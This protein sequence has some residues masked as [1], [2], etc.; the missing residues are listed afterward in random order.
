[1]Y[2]DHEPV[3]LAVRFVTK[4]RKRHPGS[5]TAPASPTLAEASTVCHPNFRATCVR[6]A[7]TVPN[8]ALQAAGSVR[9][10]C[11]TRVHVA[12]TTLYRLRAVLLCE[13]PGDGAR[14]ARAGPLG[15]RGA[16]RLAVRVRDARG[17]P[18]V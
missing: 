6:Q 7:P 13:Q 10:R 15:A 8:P 3:K 12:D 4:Q 9:P 11:H 1:M 5:S 2:R 14:P 18:A 17:H 16:D